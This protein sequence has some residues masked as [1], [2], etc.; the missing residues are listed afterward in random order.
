MADSVHVKEERKIQEH[1]PPKERSSIRSREE[2]IFLASGVHIGTQQKSK[3]MMP[4]IFR[5]RNDGLYVLDIKKSIDRIKKAAKLLARYEPQDILAVSARQ[6]GQRPVKVF[7]EMIGCK[8]FA[9][10]FIPGTLTNPNLDTYIEPEIIIIT[11]PYADSQALNEAI[12]TG[13]PVVAFCDANNNTKYVDLVIPANNKGRK[14]LATIYWLL[15]REVMKELGRIE[16]DSEYKLE[17][18]DFEATI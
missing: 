13:L 7:A 16:D 10:R 5:I 9:G 11:D 14:S 3:D 18:D 12:L 1:K 4:F 6:Y 17:I 8:Y 2:E 15:T